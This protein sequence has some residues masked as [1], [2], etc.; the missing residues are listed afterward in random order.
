M[1]RIVLSVLV[2]IG[3]AIQSPAQCWRQVTAHTAVNSLSHHVLGIQSDGTLWAW[4]DNSYGQLGDGTTTTRTVP[5]QVGTASDWVYVSA[6]STSSYAIKQDGSLW[7]WGANDYGQLSDGTTTSRVLPAQVLPGTTWRK[8]SAGDAFV[9]AQKTDGTLWSCGFNAFNQLG[10]PI[11]GEADVYTLTQV[12][13]DT[14]WLDYKSSHRNTVLLKNNH[15]Y[16]CWGYGYFGSLA[17]GTD[18][19]SDHPISPLAA[20]DWA[21]VTNGTDTTL[22]IK[23][24]GTL[25]G[26]GVKGYGTLGLGSFVPYAEYTLTQVGNATNWSSVDCS[27]HSMAIKTDGTLWA[28]GNNS[29][30]QL[31]LG[32]TTNVST[33]TQVGTAT[34]WSKVCC[35]K[36]FTLALDTNGTLWA[37][38]DNTSGQLG[39]GTTTNRLVP[40][41]IGTACTMATH[42]FT[43]TNMHLLN[44]PVTNKIQLS[45]DGDGTKDVSVYNSLG[46]LLERKTISSDVM[47]IDVSGYA[48]GVYFVTCTQE[49]AIQTEKVVK[50]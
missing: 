10:N 20:S 44:N 19:G 24:N 28:T 37:W 8:V 43:K 21:Q 4:G 6:G 14:D 35:G 49:G 13:P 29:S 40:I 9:V 27:L 7:A 39:D 30:G 2:W 22:F 32:T 15:T 1:K 23:T 34:H 42:S 3:F 48:R 46:V 36:D 26:V 18:V 33:L 25:W 50:E 12:S 45:F 11:A 41:Q 5:T 47:S 31:G 17:T 16:W 38:G